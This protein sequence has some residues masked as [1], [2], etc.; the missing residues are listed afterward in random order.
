MKIGIEI[1]FYLFSKGMTTIES[2]PES[3]LHS[4]VNLID[5]FDELY[6][7]MKAHNIALEFMH[8]ECGGG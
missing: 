6:S 5:E 3:S 7:F 8:K 1:E 4:L 2:N